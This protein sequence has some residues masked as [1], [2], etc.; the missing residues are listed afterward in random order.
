MR[1][2]H[3]KRAARIAQHPPCDDP[4]VA[5]FDIDLQRLRSTA[6]LRAETRL[7]RDL[8]VERRVIRLPRSCA[9]GQSAG[10]CDLGINALGARDPAALGKLCDQ[11]AVKLGV[12]DHDTLAHY[13]EIFERSSIGDGEVQEAFAPRQGPRQQSGQSGNRGRLSQGLGEDREELLPP[14]GMDPQ[15]LVEC[16]DRA[17]IISGLAAFLQHQHLKDRVAPGE[18]RRPFDKRLA[19]CRISLGQRQQNVSARRK[20]LAPDRL[21]RLICCRAGIARKIRHARQAARRS[22]GTIRWRLQPGIGRQTRRLPDA[23][24]HCAVGRLLAGQAVPQEHRERTLGRSLQGGAAKGLCPRQGCERERD[25]ARQK[26]PCQAGR[27]A[28]RLAPPGVTPRPIC[29]SP[30]NSRRT[31]SRSRSHSRNHSR[32]CWAPAW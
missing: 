1:Q 23:G 9:L 10:A 20:R 22:S 32:C 18:L 11:L 6:R 27:R 25:Q 13:G 30:R 2:T 19:P 5:G 16:V 26:H 15:D 8:P 29:L 12:V 3:G 21:A 4:A 24:R 31:R 17:E 7:V 14:L 28:H